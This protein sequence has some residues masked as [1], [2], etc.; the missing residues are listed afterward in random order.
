[1]DMQMTI[2]LPVTLSRKITQKAR[3]LGRRRSDVVRLA[4]TGF[5]E[6]SESSLPSQPSPYEHVKHLIGSVHT[7]VSDLGAS[8]RKYLIR[9]FKH[10]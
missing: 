6:N 8:H 7:G 1:M 3:H 10:A 2:R 5:L 4:L 9:K